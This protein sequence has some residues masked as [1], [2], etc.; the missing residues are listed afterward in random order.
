MAFR[1][2]VNACAALSK[3]RF[4]AFFL[5]G[6]SRERSRHG[7]LRREHEHSSNSSAAACVNAP[8]T[9]RSACQALD[10]VH[11]PSN[12]IRLYYLYVFGCIVISDEKAVLA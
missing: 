5:G 2:F 10:A 8:L 3:L 1:T 12:V 7:H 6:H 4:T 9:G 11:Q